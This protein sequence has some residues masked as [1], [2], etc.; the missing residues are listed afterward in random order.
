MERM[1]ED[2]VLAQVRKDAA[3]GRTVRCAVC[4][5]GAEGRVSAC[6]VCGTTYH[7]DCWSYNGGCAVYGCRAA[8]RRPD[9][10]HVD[11]VTT[12]VR[13]GR[14][15]T[16]TM[17][18]LAVLFFGMAL[19]ERNATARTP[20]P[21]IEDDMAALACTVE[22]METAR[23]LESLRRVPVR[24]HP[25]AELIASVRRRLIPHGGQFPVCLVVEGETVEVRGPERMV[26]TVV[27]SLRDLDIPAEDER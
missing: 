16:M 18:A 22:V 2:Q 7:A 3:G 8:P 5:T 20:E 24:Y 13:A 26:A 12:R 15:F 21:D 19:G 17:G 6:S 10:V 27:R 11:V 23:E 4:A 14:W 9:A 1:E 25:P